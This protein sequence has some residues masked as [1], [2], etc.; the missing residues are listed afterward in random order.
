RIRAERMSQAARRLIDLQYPLPNQPGTGNNFI[1]NP[2]RPSNQDAFDLRLD[3]QLARNDSLFARY[4]LADFDAGLTISPRPVL[5]NSLVGT[6]TPLDTDDVT[7]R[8]QFLA[9]SNTH[10]FRSNLINESRFGYTRFNEV[11]NNRLHG[12]DAAE[13]VGIHN[14]NRPD[15]PFSSGL[16]SI[17]IS[18]FSTIGELTFL[19]FINVINTFQYIDNLSYI[20]GRHSLKFG[21]DVRRRQYNF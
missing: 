13:R 4:G 17:S 5:A 9:L 18:A 1:Y 3:H 7:V 8:N 10:T 16:P 21:A 11:A 15:L 20:K 6:S 12:I 2:I 19:P 14:L